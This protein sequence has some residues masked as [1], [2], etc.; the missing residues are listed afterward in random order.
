MIKNKFYISLKKLVFVTAVLFM[1]LEDLSPRICIKLSVCEY[2]VAFGL[3]YYYLN[4]K[5]FDFTQRQKV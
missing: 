1:S 2:L 3:S 4:L 5:K